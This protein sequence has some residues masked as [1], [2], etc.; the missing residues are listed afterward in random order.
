MKYGGN[1]G[2]K[3]GGLAV[4]GV[5]AAVAD[6]ERERLANWSTGLSNVIDRPLASVPLIWS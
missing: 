3:V 2:G 4:A 6:A 1:A 5:S